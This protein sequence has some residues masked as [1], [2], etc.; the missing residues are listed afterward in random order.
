[1]ITMTDLNILYALDDGTTP[2][3]VE[4]ELG[5]RLGRLL[6]ED[7][8]TRLLRDEL[9]ATEGVVVRD[10]RRAATDLPGLDLV[11]VE[12]LAKEPDRVKSRALQVETALNLALP[13]VH[14]RGLRKAELLVGRLAEQAPRPLLL[15]TLARWV[16]EWTTALTRSLARVPLDHRSD[17]VLAKQVRAASERLG[18]LERRW[19]ALAA[20]CGAAA[21][22]PW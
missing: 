2:V 5:G 9:G 15:R 14:A 13:I 20:S 12:L 3:V 11:T 4:F 6:G 8:L 17:H 19:P 7:L 22:P 18:L 1:M 10:V 16:A 21:T